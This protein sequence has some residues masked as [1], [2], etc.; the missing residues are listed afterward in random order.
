[1]C[2][3]PTPA[4]YQ[5]LYRT[6]VC[7]DVP[8][9]IDAFN[10]CDT[11][12]NVLILHFPSGVTTESCFITSRWRLYHRSG[13]GY[14]LTRESAPTKDCTITPGNLVIVYVHSATDVASHL[15]VYTRKRKGGYSR[16]SAA[17]SISKGCSA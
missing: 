6:S 12:V 8:P 10:I 11:L 1:M 5:R 9:L 3:K 2:V 4:P 13:G 14:E 16:P 7:T 17:E 15:V